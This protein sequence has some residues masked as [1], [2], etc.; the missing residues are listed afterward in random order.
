MARMTSYYGTLGNDT[1]NGG[2]G[3]DTIY[4]YAKGGF[5]DEEF[6]ND[7]L[8]GGDGNDRIYAGGGNDILKGDAGSD[9]LY[10]GDGDDILYAGDGAN[11]LDGGA[12]NDLFILSSGRN[13][14]IFGGVGI[15]TVKFD[16]LY[17]RRDLILDVNS[18]IEILDLTNFTPTGS[19][20]VD[21]FDLSGLSTILYGGRAIDLGAGN[22]SY[23]GH[24]GADWARGGDGSDTLTG[25]DGNDTLSGDGGQNSFFGGNGDDLFLIAGINS[26]VTDIGY[27]R[28]TFDGASG[29]DTVR[30]EGASDRRFLILDAQAGVEVLDQA[31]FRLS[32][33][34]FAD[35]FDFSG[36]S[37]LI[38]NGPRIDLKA[39]ND[40]YTGFSG[41][42]VVSGGDG[43]DTL[44][45]GLGNDDL[46]GGSGIDSLAGGA[47]DDRYVVDNTLDKVDEAGG[48]GIDSVFSSVSFSL[49]QSARVLGLFENLTLVGS[50]AINGTGNA[51]ANRITGNA[52]NN[53]L[54]GG[55]GVD[56][57]V[58][59]AGNDTYFTDGSDVISEALNA[60]IDTVKSS[61]SLTLGAN[62][63]NLTL[64]GT[65]ALNGTGNA[66]ANS[67]TGNAANNVLHGGG[68]M[69]T[70][71]GGAGRD[72]LYGGAADATRDV[73]VFNAVTDSAKGAARDVIFDFVSGVDDISLS[74]IDANG[75]LAG[76]QAF[77]W[78]GTT[79]T[80]NAV[81]YTV[82]GANILVRGD[83]DGDAV[84][85]FEIQIAGIGSL[86]NADVV[87]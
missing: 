10:A 69:D 49:V 46:D 50:A 12:G 25:G 80:A 77:T 3:A 84:Y 1:I 29:N 7:S 71:V 36:L 28:D 73:F 32:G 67:I 47:G 16:G 60:G 83:V 51:L 65:A 37:R 75:S 58:G 19:T 24:V 9:A 39:G 11:Y 31:G 53:V 15:D 20:F 18:A 26:N 82:S 8:R 81:W 48:S 85:D 43:A 61:V 78:G 23:I 76:N 87:L 6:G 41:N 27:N 34:V 52:A 79:A 56:T 62:L 64:T 55:A 59:G 45:G 68:G 57:L 42:D 21:T 86:T 22:D 4:G 35:V 44:I 2:T 70:L 17:E 30:L 13:E 40:Q 66:L 38:Y 5:P 63:E 33:S 74:G 72:L 14:D 54:I